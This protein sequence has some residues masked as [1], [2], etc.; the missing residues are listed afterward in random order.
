MIV[1]LC[2]TCVVL[3]LVCERDT[4]FVCTLPKL[5]QKQE[6]VSVMQIAGLP[7]PSSHKHGMHTVMS[8]HPHQTIF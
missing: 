4:G 8:A 7:L 2:S 3:V 5:I 1:S 6:V